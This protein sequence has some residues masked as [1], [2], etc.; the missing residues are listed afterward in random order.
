MFLG[1]QRLVEAFGIAPARHHAAGELVDDDDGVVLDDVVLVALE[2]LVGA[3]RLL[4][5]VHDR[6]VLGVVEIGAAQQPGFA[7]HLLQMHV[8]LLGQGAG[9]LLLVEIVVLGRQRRDVLVHRIVEVGLVVDGAGDDERGARLVDQ[10]RVDFVDDR[11]IVAALHHL[12]EMILHVVAQIV[13]AQFVVGGVGHVA[14]IGH[15]ALLVGEAVHDDAGGEAEETVDLAHPARVAAGEIVV[16][17][18]DMDALAGQRVE[19][20]GKGGDQRLAF[21]GLHF[22]DAGLRAAPCRRSAARRSGAGPG[23]AWRPRARWRRRAPGC[24]RGSCPR[25]AAR[26]TWRSGRAAPRRTAPR[27]RAPAR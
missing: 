2:Q 1:F 15:A 20:D 3:Q 18:D 17:G 26:G 27:F 6:H 24:R 11:V 7:Q 5:V 9:A 22:G 14:G 10:D 23:C 21:A 25:P 12:L 16:D 8:A 13:E 19:V 4:D